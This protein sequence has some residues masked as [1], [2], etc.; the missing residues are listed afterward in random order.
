[1]TITTDQAIALA[2]EVGA[3]YWNHGM[4][5]DQLTTLCNKVERDTLLKAAGQ[6]DLAKAAWEVGRKQALLEAADQVRFDDDGTE[7]AR[8]LRRMAGEE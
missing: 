8:K 2:Q 1:M 3:N 5:A 6:L 4:N 7:S